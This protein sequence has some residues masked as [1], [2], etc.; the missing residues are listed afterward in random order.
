MPTAKLLTIPRN[1]ALVNAVL[2][3]L[4]FEVWH[5]KIASR[6]S[7]CLRLGD[8]WLLFRRYQLHSAPEAEVARSLILWYSMQ[9]H[10]TC[11]HS[12]LAMDTVLT[13]PIESSCA[14][15]ILHPAPRPLPSLGSFNA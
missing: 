2:T 6:I 1:R 11:A 12:W 8:G 7:A 10:F 9:L 13:L 5:P 15:C 3:P 4:S 14:S